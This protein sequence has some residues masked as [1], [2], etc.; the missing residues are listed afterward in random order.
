MK[1]DNP[2]YPPWHCFTACLCDKCGEMHEADREHIC[3]RKNSY[4]IREQKDIKC[5]YSSVDRCIKE[6]ALDK[7][8]LEEGD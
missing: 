1:R 5:P 8:I 4:P 3:K 6:L 7:E 2:K